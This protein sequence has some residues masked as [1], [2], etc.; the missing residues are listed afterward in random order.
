MHNITDMCIHKGKS[1]K[2]KQVNDSRKGIPIIY[3]YIYIYI[4]YVS[5]SPVK[6]D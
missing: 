3:I 6:L 4:Y 5:F 2:T 1:R